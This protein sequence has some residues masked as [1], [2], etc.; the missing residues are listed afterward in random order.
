MNKLTMSKIANDYKALY[1]ITNRCFDIKDLMEETRDKDIF[2]PFHGE[3]R[4]SGSKPS[5]RFYTN[6]FPSKLWCFQERR[7][8]YS[9]HYIK[10][11]LKEN[12]FKYLLKHSNEKEI[13]YYYD[14]YKEYAEEDEQGEINYSFSSLDE[15]NE[16][17]NTQNINKDYSNWFIV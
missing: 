3:S 17:Y 15:I 1:Y 4:L 11:I 8:Y 13:L 10:L 16:L 7:S 2:C 9:Y 12:V 14:E 6:V 5:A